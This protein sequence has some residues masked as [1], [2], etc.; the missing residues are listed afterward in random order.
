[1]TWAKLHAQELLIYHDADYSSHASSA[2]SMA[3]GFNTALSELNGQVQGYTLKLVPKDHRGNVKRSK[4]HIRQ[5]LSDPNV[6]AILGGLHSPPYLSNRQF[7]NQNEVLLLVPWAAAGPI[8]RYSEGANWVFRVSIDDTQA[9]ARLAQFA[10]ENKSCKAPHLLLENTGWGSSNLRTLKHALASFGVDT[11]NVT[12]FDWNTQTNAAREIIENIQR[13]GSDCIVF[14]G[15][16]IEGE[17]FL[18]ALAAIDNPLPVI[19]HWGI[20][21]GEFDSVFRDRLVGR[22][23]LSFLQTCF[24][25]NSGKLEGLGKQV[26]D[27]AV[28]LFPDSLQRPEDIKAPPGFIHAYDMGRILLAALQQIDLTGDLKQDRRLLRTA[29]EE[30]QSPV[31][32]LVKTYSRPFSPWSP[33]HPNAHE[34]LSLDNLCMANFDPEGIIRLIQ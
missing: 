3:M 11:I 19:S 20:T 30:I 17:V 24:S 21:G 23:D 13:T 7:I 4:L 27:Q 5:Y 9:G 12:R 33:E 16:A 6:L 29:L 32:G 1:M 22:I 10:V 14:V 25:F 26:F 8:T 2:N 34:A 28:S 31:E 15:N 18:N